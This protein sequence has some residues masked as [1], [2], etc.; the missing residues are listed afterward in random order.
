MIMDELV[1]KNLFCSHDKALKHH[2]AGSP[3][4]VFEC[5]PDAISSS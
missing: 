2:S 1:L 3:E 5:C 4:Y